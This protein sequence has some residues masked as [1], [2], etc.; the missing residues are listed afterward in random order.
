MAASLATANATCHTR[1]I[2]LPSRTHPLT[3]KLEDHLCRLRASSEASSSSSVCRRLSNLTN[4]YGHVDDML[5]LPQT[6]KSLSHERHENWVEE[7]IDGSLRMLDV[8]SNSRD[9]FLQ[10]KE[11]MQDLELSL[12]RKRSGDSGMVK[13]VSKYMTSRKKLN[14]VISKCYES[15]KS[16]T[17][18]CVP[19][20]SDKSNANALVSLLQEVEDTS[21]SVFESLLCHVSLSKTQSKTSGWSVVS[22]L[23]GTKSLSCE[24]EVEINEVEKLDAMLL[25]LNSKNVNKGI[26]SEQMKN[27]LK[28]LEASEMH[29][30]E[31][32]EGLECAY[33][34]LVKARVALL[35]ILSH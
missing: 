17:K 11:S 34:Q 22:K 26:N 27:V 18:K 12:R 6:Q 7:V 31:L 24:G 25:R 13:E 19:V 28:S 35:N 21:F 32:E 10:M 23:L 8:C 29:I 14:K 5:Q 3:A 15:V 4:L 33:R 2:S 30:R 1:S 16:S 9:V 20:N